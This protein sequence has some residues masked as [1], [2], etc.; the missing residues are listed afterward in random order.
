MNYNY[1]P[2]S[3][4]VQA[5][6]MGNSLIESVNE[7]YILLDEVAY[8]VRISSQA[9]IIKE[10]ALKR[11]VRALRAGKVHEN[12]EMYKQH[13]GNW[14]YHRQRI[15]ESNWGLNYLD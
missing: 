9:P 15:I 14:E 6:R 4:S 13:Y 10:R 7:G 5:R 3:W 11:F 1:H 12:F 2:K 8:K